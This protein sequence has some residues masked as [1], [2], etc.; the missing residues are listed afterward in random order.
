MKFC[1]LD[2]TRAPPL[3][4]QN[5]S[6]GVAMGRAFFY[7][8][9]IIDENRRIDARLFEGYSAAKIKIGYIPSCGDKNR[10]FFLKQCH[11]YEQYGVRNFL[12]FDL[13]EEYDMTLTSALLDCDIVHISGG[14]PIYCLSN[15]RR[16]NFADILR[17]YV[18]DGGTLVGVSGG[19]VQLGRGV[20]VFKLFT[21]SL[22]ETLNSKD[23][24]SALQITDFEFLPHYNRWE[25]KY[26]DQVKEYSQKIES[27]ILACEDGNGIIVENGDMNFIGNVIKIEKG[28]ETTV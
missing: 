13:G 18:S 8:D 2:V 16:R 7:S 26:K 25:A 28:N 15:I 6:E 14:D 1:S 23:T 19:A 11:Y 21:S 9:Q 27:I 12:F 4:V 10:F 24:L 20:G 17:R 22:D 3:G 5:K